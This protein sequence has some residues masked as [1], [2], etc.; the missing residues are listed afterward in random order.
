M[1]AMTVTVKA[2]DIQR[3]ICLI[4]LFQFIRDSFEDQ[5]RKTNGLV[6]CSLDSRLF[7]IELLCVLG[8]QPLPAAKLHRV[9]PNDASDGL[10]C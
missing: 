6:L 9:W 1:L 7:N 10:I 4:H 2:M 3:W 5:V 8:V